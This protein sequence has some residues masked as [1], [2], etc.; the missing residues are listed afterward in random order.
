VDNNRGYGPLEYLMTKNTE[1]KNLLQST[2]HRDLVQFALDKECTIQ[3]VGLTNELDIR[4]LDVKDSKTDIYE[5][6]NEIETPH[7]FNV[8]EGKCCLVFHCPN[9]YYYWAIVDLLEPAGGC[10]IIK[11]S[12]GVVDEWFKS[13][14]IK[15]MN[16]SKQDGNLFIHTTPISKMT[17]QQWEK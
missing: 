11:D 12:G 3:V 2:A 13:W 14:Y 15:T 4:D 1:R 7:L 6:I 10:T 17:A 5:I 8:N 9:T 16:N